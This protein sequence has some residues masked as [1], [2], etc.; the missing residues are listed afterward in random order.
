[1][2]AS[3]VVVLILAA[4]VASWMTIIPATLGRKASSDTRGQD[5][6]ELLPNEPAASVR[7]RANRSETANHEVHDRPASFKSVVD[8]SPTALANTQA[9]V[10][11][12]ARNVTAQKHQPSL[13]ALLIDQKPRTEVGKDGKKDKDKNDATENKG[14]QQS[15]QCSEGHHPDASGNCNSECPDNTV[16]KKPDEKGNCQCKPEYK[17]FDTRIVDETEAVSKELKPENQKAIV[18]IVKKD[19]ADKGPG[20]PMHAHALQPGET[21]QGAS[22]TTSEVY[23]QGSCEHCKCRASGAQA[24]KLHALGFFLLFLVMF[25]E[26]CE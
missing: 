19:Q 10:S 15:V 6:V 12:L 4:S 21:A 16:N 11:G 2:S 14:P 20:C 3:N 8:S 22:V 26:C 24:T 25:S 13:R 5:S 1:M 17:C 7:A 18:E 23:F 9:S